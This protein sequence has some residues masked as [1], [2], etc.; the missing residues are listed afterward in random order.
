MISPSGSIEG[1]PQEGGGKG[2]GGGTLLSLRVW[3][4]FCKREGKKGQS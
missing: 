4:K 1:D 2:Y 3:G